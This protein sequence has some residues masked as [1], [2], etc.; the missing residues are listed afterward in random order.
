MATLKSGHSRVRRD[1][2]MSLVEILVGVV[3]GL[4]GI[5]V[6]FQVLAVAESRKRT[7]IHGGDAQSAGAIALYS[8]QRD[9][10]V[11]GYGFGGSETGQLGCLVKAHDKE[12]P[13]INLDFRLF[14]VEIVQGE[15]IPGP[16]LGAAGSPD[17]IVAVWGTSSQFVTSR[18][19]SN[20]AAAPR[21]TGGR[22]GID[23]GDLVILTGNPANVTPAAPKT[24]CALI[25][26]TDRP[27]ADPTELGYDNDYTVNPGDTLRTCALA[28]YQPDCATPTPRFYKGAAWAAPDFTPASGFLI[29]LGKQPRRNAWEVC[30]AAAAGDARSPCFN[31]LDLV[32]R[33][34]V[35]DS[36]FTGDTAPVGASVFGNAR[37]EAAD[38]IVNLQ[39]EYGIDRNN[40]QLLE[41]NEWTVTPPD[42]AQLPSDPNAPC[43]IDNPVRSWRCVRA[44]R[45][46]LLARS[47]QWD[48]TFCAQN[49]PRWTSGN[50]GAL[51]LTDFVM[52]N[53]EDG[54][55]DT[56]GGCTE[57]PPSPNNWRRYRY[58]VYETVI[59]L[60][61]M[62]WGTAP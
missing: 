42:D 23:Y 25:Q 29:N 49:P 17:R 26:L 16:G 62:I 11:G 60:R 21:L 6:I 30:T 53:A 20:N 34:I 50:S 32:N 38:N 12:R 58:S 56:F 51:V 31:R 45:V 36:L 54:L 27:V 8:L 40:N 19:W 55:A 22:G 10:Q 3:I 5:V 35:A 2:G 15:N 4:I 7:T 9:V 57:N 43:S 39:A 46:A 59:P 18:A 24:E 1:R 28:Q 52:T 61:N 14:P 44:I 48:P 13:A 47:T 37:T 33:L 41:A